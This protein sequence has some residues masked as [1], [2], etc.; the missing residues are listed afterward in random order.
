MTYEL[1]QAKVKAKGAATITNK[2][3]AAAIEPHQ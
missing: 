1:A 2:I 3:V